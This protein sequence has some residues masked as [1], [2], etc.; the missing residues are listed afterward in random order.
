MNVCGAFNELNY[1]EK[2]T[3]AHVLIELHFCFNL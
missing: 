3:N 2:I 1:F